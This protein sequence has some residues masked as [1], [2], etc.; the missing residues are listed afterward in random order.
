MIRAFDI[1]RAWSNWAKPT[2]M[3]FIRVFTMV[4]GIL[5]MLSSV[6]AGIDSIDEKLLESETEILSVFSNKVII[7]QFVSGVLPI[8]WIGLGAIFAGILLSNWMGGIPRQISDILRIVVFGGFVS[9]SISIY[10]YHD[11]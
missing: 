5:L 9:N 6:P 1:D 2:P 3:G 4:T 11:K 8:L 7:G 10:K